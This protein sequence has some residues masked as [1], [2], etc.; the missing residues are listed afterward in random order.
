MSS[1]ELCGVKQYSKELRE[2]CDGLGLQFRI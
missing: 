1:L 2:A